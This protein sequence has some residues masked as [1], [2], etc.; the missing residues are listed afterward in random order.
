[1]P[2]DDAD[3]LLEHRGKVGEGFR[4]EVLRQRRLPRALIADQGCGRATGEPTAGGLV[5]GSEGEHVIEMRDIELD[6][7]GRRGRVCGVQNAA[8]GELATQEVQ[9]R[10]GLNVGIVRVSLRRSSEQRPESWV[11]QRVRVIGVLPAP[12]RRAAAVAD[13]EWMLADAERPGA[14]LLESRGT[15]ARAL[16]CRTLRRW[17]TLSVTYSSGRCSPWCGSSTTNTVCQFSPAARDQLSDPGPSRHAL[18]EAVAF[19]D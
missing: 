13:F 15:A 8:A 14:A 10:E 3:D 11:Q 6:V 17:T 12:G 16:P 5:A 18:A 9:R 4:E 19:A 2:L 7:L 1:M